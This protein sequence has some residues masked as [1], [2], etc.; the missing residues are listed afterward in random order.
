MKTILLDCDGV[1]A[2]L[3]SH[4]CASINESPAKGAPLTPLDFREYNFA[5]TLKGEQF[6]EA[7]SAMRRQGFVRSVPPYIGAASFVRTLQKTCRVYCVTAATHTPHWHSERLNWLAMLN[8]HERDVIF[9]S[10]KERISG[11]FLIEDHPG[12]CVRWLEENPTGRALL[13][14]RPW[15]HVGAK[16]YKFH[17]R[18]KRVNNLGHALQIVGAE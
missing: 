13:V 15:N 4:L 8:I 5:D 16:G 17:S 18:L 2:D 7:N 3:V 6:V 11:D 12:H 10:S 1:L 14:D 9:T